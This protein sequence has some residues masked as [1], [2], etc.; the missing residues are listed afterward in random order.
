M[1]DPGTWLY[2]STEF[3]DAWIVRFNELTPEAKLNLLNLYTHVSKLLLHD[4]DVPAQHLAKV[5]HPNKLFHE[6]NLLKNQ[7]LLLNFHLAAIEYFG[8]V[9]DTKLTHRSFVYIAGHFKKAV[10]TPEEVVRLALFFNS[11]SQ[12]GMTNDFLSARI[13][14]PDF[15]ED[16]AFMLMSTAFVLNT[17]TEEQLQHCIEK[18]YQLNPKRW[19][20][21]IG[22]NFQLRRDSFVKTKVCMRCG[23]E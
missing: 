10:L 6:A 5:I 11:W 17:Q 18:A 20:E 4:W 9:N 1:K 19:C 3:L 22:A 12:Y 2:E 21:Y 13:D 15:S 14:D 23:D 16:A 8:Q 7:T